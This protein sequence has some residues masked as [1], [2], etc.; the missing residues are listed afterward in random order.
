MY[1]VKFFKPNY[2]YL[3]Y[4]HNIDKNI[5]LSKN[6]FGIVLRINEFIYFLPIDSISQTDYD[7][8]SNIRKTTPTILRMYDFKTQNYLGKCLFSNMFPIP[9]KDLIAQ[10]IKSLDE[11]N[12]LLN[13][14]KLEYLKNNITRINKS[15]QRLYKQK[16]KNYNQSYLL[17]TVDFKELEEAAIKWEI[18]HYNKHYNRFPDSQFF[19]TNPFDS[20][21][22]EYFLMNKNRKIAK[23]ILDNKLQKVNE[24]VEVFNTDY[25]PLECFSHHNLTADSITRWFRGRGIP[26]WRDGLDDLLDNLGIKD[27]DM[28][29]NK[30]FGLSLSDQYWLNPIKMPMDWHDINFFNHNFSS[31]NFYEAVFENKLQSIKDI[32]LFSPNNTSDGM[33]KK[34]WVEENGRKYLLKGSYKDKGMEPF[35]EVLASMLCHQLELNHVEYSIEVINGIIVSKCECFINDTTELLS[36]YSILKYNNVD[37]SLSPINIY[38]K[39]LSILYNHGIDTAKTD[40]I[41]M[42]LLDYIIANSDRHLGNFGVIRNVETLVWECVAPNFDSG[43]ALNSQKEIYEMNFDKAYGCFFNKKEIEFDDLFDILKD[44]INFRIDFNAIIDVVNEWENLL[45]KYQPYS[46]IDSKKIEILIKGLKKRIEKLKYKLDTNN[47][48]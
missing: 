6:L 24:I 13:E 31:Q 21:V 23:I 41:K 8:N 33:L 14:K 48:A 42:F 30:A 1:I 37:M 43:Q 47:K 46:L 19:L 7:N 44:E 10:D 38:H 28:L 9:Y 18:N 45:I 12:V 29:L 35:N 27:K 36:A 40:F 32:D 17:A 34:V 22:S 39:Y 4:I 2:D 25:A 3:E 20:G 5:I 15:A 16:N 26:T 11:N